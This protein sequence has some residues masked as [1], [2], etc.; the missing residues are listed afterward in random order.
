[1]FAED[2]DAVALVVQIE[3]VVGLNA[4]LVVWNGRLFDD[5]SLGVNGQNPIDQLPPGRSRDAALGENHLPG[6]EEWSW[7]GLIRE[8]RI[9]LVVEQRPLLDVRR[10]H[11]SLLLFT[12]KP[13]ILYMR[14]IRKSS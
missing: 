2:Q 1:M 13:S 9:T 4:N 6:L 7:S 12:T 10:G 8:G 14:S 5:L 3:R 11:G